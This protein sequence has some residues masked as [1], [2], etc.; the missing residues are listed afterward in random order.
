MMV[1]TETS[2]AIIVSME[3]FVKGC[4]VDPTMAR[5]ADIK[6]DATFDAVLAS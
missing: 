1:S 6:K 4:L 3:T 5:N 2:L